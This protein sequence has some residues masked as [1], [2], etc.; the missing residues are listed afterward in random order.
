[1]APT[2]KHAKKVPVAVPGEGM[3]EFARRSA[4]WLKSDSFVFD[5]TSPA[6]LIELPGDILVVGGFVHVTTAFDAS[7]SAAAATAT[8]SVPNDTGTE[9]LFDASTILL[10]TTGFHPVTGYAL[11]PSSGGYLIATYTAG[12]TTQ[13]ALEVYLAYVDKASKL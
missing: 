12:T 13:G 11:V 5:D 8:I 3:S 6:N 1:M 10:Q 2:L 9:T 4:Q 7:G